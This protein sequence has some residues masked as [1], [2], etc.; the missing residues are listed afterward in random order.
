MNMLEQI[1]AAHMEQPTKVSGVR[2][3]IGDG[4]ELTLIP[5]S[6]AQLARQVKL[7]ELQ[8]ADRFIAKQL[9]TSSS[10]PPTAVEV[11]QQAPPRAQSREFVIPWEVSK[12]RTCEFDRQGTCVPVI[13]QSEGE[14]ISERTR[15]KAFV[16]A[17]VIKHGKWKENERLDSQW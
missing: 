4:D 15:R 13:F 16:S 10:A 3:P 12:P 6:D 2:Y 14:Q 1:A 9:G 7:Q 17:F 11:Q 8:E 5:E